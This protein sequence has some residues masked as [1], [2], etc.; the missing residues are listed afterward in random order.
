MK[1]NRRYRYDKMIKANAWTPV[2]NATHETL[3][4]LYGAEL[5]EFLQLAA[6][7]YIVD[8]ECALFS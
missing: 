8:K 4:I 7:S 1:A 2:T 5:D 6:K 3:D